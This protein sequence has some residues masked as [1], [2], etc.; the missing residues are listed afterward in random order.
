MRT[1]VHLEFAK[2]LDPAHA[3]LKANQQPWVGSVGPV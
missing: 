2:S 3:N 1:L